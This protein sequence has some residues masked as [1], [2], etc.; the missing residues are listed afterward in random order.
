M[1]NRI[2]GALLLVAFICPIQGNGQAR[3]H[4]DNTQQHDA[5]PQTIVVNVASP[6]RTDQEAADQKSKDNRDSE[7]QTRN[8]WLTCVIALAAFVQAGV[9]IFQWSVYRKQYAT[10]SET[11]TETR[12]SADAA[13]KGIAAIESLERPFL[14][15]ELR[16][17]TIKDEVWIVNKGK[18]PAQIIWYNPHGSLIM[19][20]HE[21]TENL[22]PNFDYGYLHNVETAQVVNVPWI[23]PGGEMYLTQFAWVDLGEELTLAYQSGQ[24]FALLLS[25]VKYRGMLTEKIYESRWCFRW[26]GNQY[27]LKL[28]GPYGYNSYT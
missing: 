20:T 1:N 26:L 14:M 7:I 9:S 8:F 11:L 6:K 27:G 21:Q 17:N 19:K 2:L 4:A 3:T 13:M 24:Q 25:T 16:G 5:A 12:K 10:M 28:F 18:I 15:V 23:A 22:P